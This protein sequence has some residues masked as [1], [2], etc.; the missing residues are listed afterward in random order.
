MSA[1]GRGARGARGASRWLEPLLAAVV[2]AN[3]A[4]ALWY[5]YTYGYLPQ[6]FFYSPS[7]MWGD[8]F[9]VVYWSY[10]P[11]TYDTYKTVYPPLSFVFLRVFSLGHCYPIVGNPLDYSAGLAARDCDWL[12]IVTF[13]A[14]YLATI[15]VTAV[16]YWR[17]DRRTA[18]WR[19]YALVAGFP[20]LQGLEHANLIIP[21]FLL[22]VLAFGPLVRSARVRWLCLGLAVNFK[23]YVIAAIMPGLIRRR[24]LWTEGALIACV[25][26]WLVTYAL[27]GRGTPGEVYENI[28]A[29]AD[30]S[31][32]TFLDVWFPATNAALIAMLGH[33]Q[34]P[35]LGILGSRNI[36]ILLVALPAAQ[37]IAQ[38]AIVLAC[39]AAW[40]RP[41]CVT[42]HRLT[43]F[44]IS[45]ALITSESGGYTVILIFFFTFLEQWRG[46]GAKWAIVVCYIL[47][48]PGDIPVDSFPEAVAETF[49]PANTVIQRFSVMIGPFLRPTLLLTVPLALSLSTIADVWRDV[50]TAGWRGRRRFRHDLPLFTGGLPVAAE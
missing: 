34:S 17:A 4:Y 26:V 10:D 29:F 44:G 1:L 24:W 30:S 41:E 23:I 50:R 11:G 2:M 12:G 33:W 45:F 42:R 25:A 18:L 9:N 40:L 46:F 16:T 22:V 13:H 14:I 8:W 37:R 19:S 36:D 48:I 47:C 31:A 6:P 49:L 7:D 20:M 38:L 27:L 3:F 39:A 35:L 28:T 15:V 43:N 5:W 32:S 21:T